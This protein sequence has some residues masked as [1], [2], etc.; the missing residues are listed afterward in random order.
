ML[1]GGRFD[2][3]RRLGARGLT[4]GREDS[5]PS[6]AVCVV[7]ALPLP[8]DVIELVQGLGRCRGWAYWKVYGGRCEAAAW[9]VHEGGN[10]PTPIERHSDPRLDM[11]RILGW[12][13]LMKAPTL[14]SLV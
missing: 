14:S 10:L 5:F 9:V 12:T 7:G 1:R 13:T 3:A 2:R 11:L 4:L 8:D 6:S